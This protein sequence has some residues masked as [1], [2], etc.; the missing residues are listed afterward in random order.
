MNNKR[1]LWTGLGLSVIG[2]AVF[3][4]ARQP[5]AGILYLAMLVIKGVLPGMGV[6]EKED[7]RKSE[8]RI[9]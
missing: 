5:Y 3:M 1:Y 7:L 8:R 9:Q 4:A 6:R 2:T